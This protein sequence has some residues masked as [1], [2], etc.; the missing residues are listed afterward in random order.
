MLNV[1]AQDLKFSRLFHFIST[2]LAYIASSKTQTME[3]NLS[4]HITFNTSVQNL[5]DC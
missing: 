5:V 2:A 1:K 3:C 4:E